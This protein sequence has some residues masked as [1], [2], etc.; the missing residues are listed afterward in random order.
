MP[1][2]ERSRDTEVTFGIF[3]IILHK[4]E[5]TQIIF[6]SAP[7]EGSSWANETVGNEERGLLL[8]PDPFPLPSQRG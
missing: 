4:K 7:P 2:P 3:T 5:K 1:S 6:S 8:H